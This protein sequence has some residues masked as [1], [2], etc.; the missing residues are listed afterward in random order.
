M[1][2]RESKPCYD[3]NNRYPTVSVVDLTSD[4]D[5]PYALNIDKVDDP[6]VRQ[7]RFKRRHQRNTKYTDCK[8]R[9]RRPVDVNDES[10]MLHVCSSQYMFTVRQTDLPTS[11]CREP[12]RSTVTNQGLLSANKSVVSVNNEALL[13]ASKYSKLLPLISQSRRV[14]HVDGTA[15]RS[16]TW[17]SVGVNSNKPRRSNNVNF[18]ANRPTARFPE[19]VISTLIDKSGDSQQYHNQRKGQRSSLTLTT[20]NVSDSLTLPRIEEVLKSEGVK[21]M[22]ISEQ[23]DKLKNKADRYKINC[24]ASTYA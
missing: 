24:R 17:P 4:V 9:R 21:S 5:L 12:Q 11:G 1:N 15:Y 6:Y 10:L 13:P 18:N 20:S 23:I 7:V 3:M 14:G 16:A 22:S 2:K 8:H 19:A